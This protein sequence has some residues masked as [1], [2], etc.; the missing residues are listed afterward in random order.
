MNLTVSGKH[1]DVT[2]AI[3]DYVQS[4]VDRIGRH[5][6]HVLDVTVILSVEKL[7]QK[8]EAE[9]HVRGKDL[10]VAIEDEDMYAAI[11]R[12]AD[13][14]DRQLIR[15]KEKLMTPRHADKPLKYRESE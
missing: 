4:K 15:H 5:F 1:F 12:M 14:L 2:P 9:V 10:F 8:A 3:R 6:D 7:R 11:D 13:R